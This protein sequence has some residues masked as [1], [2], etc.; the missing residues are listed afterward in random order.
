M[1]TS[2]PIKLPARQICLD[3]YTSPLIPDAGKSLTGSSLPRR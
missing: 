2:Y 1:K 3:F